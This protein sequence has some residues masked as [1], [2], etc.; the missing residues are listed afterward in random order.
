MTKGHE[1]T[2]EEG[3]EYTTKEIREQFLDYIQNTVQYWLKE[4]R[5][6]SVEDKLNGLAF[7]IL[8]LLDGGAADM[9]GF[10]VAPSTHPSDKEYHQ[11]NG[12][13][14]Y[15]Q[16]DDAKVNAD[17]AADSL[18]EHWYQRPDGSRRVRRG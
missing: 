14:W 12:E 15:P 5:T 2:T 13:S 9:P 6:P 18:H 17:I 8:V 7:S 11:E 4:A 1:Y 16:N 3:H 10:I